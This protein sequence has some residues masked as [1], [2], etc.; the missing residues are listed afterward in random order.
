MIEA[1][2]RFYEELNDHLPSRRRKR[3]F[4]HRFAGPAPVAD[5]IESLGVPLSEVDLI[6]VN[7]DPVAADHPV[8]NGDRVSVYPVFE[9]FDITPLVRLRSEPLRRVRFVVDPDLTELGRLLHARW[10]DTVTLGET[11]ELEPDG[12]A[13]EG[14][15]LL[16]RKSSRLHREGVTH[17]LLILSDKPRE[18][19][20]E[21]VQRLHLG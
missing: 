1:E 12:A 6:L 11:P 13:R 14:R 15:I 9:S 16:T 21:V 5:L 3:S 18:Q 2:F 4:A 7:N 17:C 20:N 19:L 10:Y 8:S